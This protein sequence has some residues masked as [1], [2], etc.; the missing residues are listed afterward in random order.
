MKKPAHTEKEALDL[1]AVVQVGSGRGF[2]VEGI[3]FIGGRERYVITAAH[4]LPER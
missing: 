3:N 1:A 4:C 2:V